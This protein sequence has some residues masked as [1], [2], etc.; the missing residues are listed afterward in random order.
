MSLTNTPTQGDKN[1]SLPSP[2]NSSFGD[3]KDSAL[4]LPENYTIEHTTTF[5]TNDIKQ[6]RRR[7]S[8]SSSTSSSF[9]SST[10]KDRFQCGECGKVYKHPNCLSKHQ[11]EHSEEWEFTSKF[12]LTKHQQVQLLEAAA[13]LMNMTNHSSHNGG[14]LQIE[15]DDL[16]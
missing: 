12:L 16:L 9:N 2:P 6:S 7:S 4:Y 11:W 8:S 15:D 3:D 5:N 13:I 14:E 10:A 1:N